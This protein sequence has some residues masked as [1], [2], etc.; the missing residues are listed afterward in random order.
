MYF[1][2]IASE[3]RL[4]TVEAFATA[5]DIQ[6]P[7]LYDENGRVHATY[8]TQSKFPSAAYPEDWIIGVDGTIVYHGNTYELE[9]MEATILNE[10]AR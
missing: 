10:L 2:G 5:F 3:D 8:P 6:M 4:E 1:F 9:E 7:L